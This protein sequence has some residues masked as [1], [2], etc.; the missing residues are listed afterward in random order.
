M[1]SIKKLEDSE[2]GTSTFEV[3]WPN[4]EIS[5]VQIPGADADERDC[6]RFILNIEDEI[7]AKLN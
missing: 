1:L 2:A 3:T 7:R 6:A 4:S 5:T